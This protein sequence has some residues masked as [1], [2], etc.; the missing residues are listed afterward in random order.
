MS[1][2]EAALLIA[3]KCGGSAPSS[4]DAQLL[5]ILKALTHRLEAALNVESLPQV[6]TVDKFDLLEMPPY[7]SHHL[8][9]TRIAGMRLTNAFLAADSTT[10]LDPDGVEVE[11]DDIYSIDRNYGIVTLSSWERGI[12][13]VTYTAGYAPE[14]APDPAPEGYDADARV[15]QGIPE[16]MKAIVVHFLVAWFRTVFLAPRV[17]KDMSYEGQ[18]RALWVETRNWVYSKYQRPRASLTFP[19]DSTVTATP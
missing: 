8:V 16:W 14:T 11:A 5:S 1:P 9:Q 15:L 10:I 4:D 6:T 13:T 17:N 19:F 12:Y 7:S 3:T 2:S 18:M